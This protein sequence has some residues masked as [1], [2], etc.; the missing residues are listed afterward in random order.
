MKGNRDLAGIR[1][2]PLSGIRL[3]ITLEGHHSLL[4]RTDLVREL[5]V[6]TRSTLTSAVTCPGKVF[7]RLTI[8]QPQEKQQTEKH[9]L[10][11]ILQ[12]LFSFNKGH[13]F[14]TL[15]LYKASSLVNAVHVL[16]QRGPHQDCLPKHYPV[17]L[18]I[19][20]VV[21]KGFLQLPARLRTAC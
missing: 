4:E 17:V 8:F 13:Q 10:I 15:P 7:G 14:P 12:Y 1:S 2:V 21:T 18:D 5:G 9:F 20:A 6:A 3:V 16:L 11:R 19:I